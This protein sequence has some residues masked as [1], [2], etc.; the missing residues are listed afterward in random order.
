MPDPDPASRP[1]LDSGFRRNDGFDICC[2]RSNKIDISVVKAN[3]RDQKP[4][5]L[6]YVDRTLVVRRSY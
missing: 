5:G 2:C 4:T 1:V 3:N 6:L